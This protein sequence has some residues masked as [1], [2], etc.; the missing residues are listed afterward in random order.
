MDELVQVA[1]AEP[2]DRVDVKEAHT[3]GGGLTQPPDAAEAAG[4]AGRA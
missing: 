3:A 1:R 4:E 2:V